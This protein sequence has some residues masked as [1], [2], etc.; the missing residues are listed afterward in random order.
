MQWSRDVQMGLKE[1][2]APKIDRP[3]LQD[4]S[5][6]LEIRANSEEPKAALQAPP[7]AA[8]AATRSAGSSTKSLVGKQEEALERELDVAFQVHATLAS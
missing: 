6:V 5:K 8:A 2:E 7:S 1:L 4:R 3:A